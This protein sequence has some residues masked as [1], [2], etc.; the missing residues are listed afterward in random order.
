MKKFLLLFY[1]LVFSANVFGQNLVPNYSFEDTVAC[2]YYY[3]LIHYSDGWSAYRNS[4]DYF[5]S[6]NSTYVGVP[7]NEAGFQYARTEN[8][9]AGFGSYQHFA[10]NHRE[11]L[12]R[13]LSQVMVIG[14]KYF[15]SMYV[16][17]SYGDVQRNYIASNKLG[18]K[19][20]T[21]PYSQTSPIPIDNFAH[22]YTDSVI[23][24]TINWT[25]ISGS[26]IADSTYQYLSIGNFFDD[27]YT[28]TFFYDTLGAWA[29]YYVDDV[30]VS[31]DS[32]IGINEIPNQN[33]QLQLFPNPTH[34]EFVVNNPELAGKTLYI[35]NTL[36]EIVLQQFIHSTNQQFRISA[37]AGIYFVR[38]ASSASATGWREKIIIY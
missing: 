25:L 6:C 30:V 12:G 33:S 1:S 36:G 13:Q 31:T 34:S 18:I 9:Y 35:Y 29:Y 22:I 16:S 20:S 21:I 23:K 11:C 32:T 7:V 38:V 15:V 37:G 17:L 8:A 24:D 14:Q 10:S 2:P 27:A 28:T 5:N 3:T 26:F 19:F 4:P